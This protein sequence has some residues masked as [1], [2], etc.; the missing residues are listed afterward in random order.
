MRTVRFEL[1]RPDEII[2]EKKRFPVVYLPIGPL[3]WHSRHLPLG[4][5]PLHAEAVARGAALETGGV[6]LPTFFWGSEMERSE[7]MLKNIGFKGDEWIV[8]MDFP[9]NSMESLYIPEDAFSIAVREYLRLLVKQGYKLI[10]IVNGH[11]GENHLRVLK[12]LAAEFTATTD[13]VVINALGTTIPDPE[14]EDSSGHATKCET[15]IL[16]YLFPDSVDLSVLP[17]K[18]EPI[19]NVEWAIVDGAAFQGNPNSDFT[20]LEDPR[21]ATAEL[22]RKLVE[23]S[24]R[25]TAKLVKENYPV[26]K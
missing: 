18:G 17:P 14:D 19:Y 21:D 15:S 11:G 10:V 23:T 6:V 2:E 22:G 24:I 20:A 1:L 7:K 5:D 16:S 26:G 3:E 8:G 9:A 4:T 25:K 13:S 12:N